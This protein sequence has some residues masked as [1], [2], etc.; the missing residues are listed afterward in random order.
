MFPADRNGIVG[1]KPSSGRTNCSG[2]IPES[3]NLDVVGTFGKYVAD[4]ATVLTAILDDVK[5]GELGRFVQLPNF[6]S[7]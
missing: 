4:A 7:P 6:D 5:R 1:I 2:I 3:R